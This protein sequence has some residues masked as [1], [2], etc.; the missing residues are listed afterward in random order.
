M[1]RTWNLSSCLLVHLLFWL[2]SG[3][4]RP[5]SFTIYKWWPELSLKDVRLQ[6]D[7]KSVQPAACTSM[8]VFIYTGPCGLRMRNSGKRGVKSEEKVKLEVFLVKSIGSNR[9]WAQKACSRCL[10]SYFLQ[11]RQRLSS[12]F[13][14]WYLSLSLTVHLRKDAIERQRLWR[15]PLFNTKEMGEQ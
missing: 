2:L 13:L 3:K 7:W 8:L 4:E 6:L 12:E 14:S 9:N 11:D 1:L 10:L 5:R 15:K